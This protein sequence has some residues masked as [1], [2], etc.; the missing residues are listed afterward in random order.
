VHVSLHVAPHDPQLLSSFEKSAHPPAQA[1]YPV[2]HAYEQLPLLQ[3]A[4]ALA[5]LVV[6]GVAVQL[7]Q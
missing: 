1:E 7:P 4:V 3:S 2:L 6:H 5:T